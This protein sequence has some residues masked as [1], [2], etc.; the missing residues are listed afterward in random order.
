[1]LLLLFYIYI[2]INKILSLIYNQMYGIIHITNLVNILTPREKL[3]L[4]LSCKFFFFFFFFFIIKK[5]II[6]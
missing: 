3:I 6:I 5:K 4:M 1:M 2:I